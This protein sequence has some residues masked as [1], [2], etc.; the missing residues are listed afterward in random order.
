MNMVNMFLDV[1]NL[2]S[3]EEIEVFQRKMFD[4][5]KN[6]IPQVVSSMRMGSN[7][8]YHP[9]NNMPTFPKQNDYYSRGMNF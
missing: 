8:F 9:N 3:T 7:S 1:P 5:Y 2:Q 6:F 4:I